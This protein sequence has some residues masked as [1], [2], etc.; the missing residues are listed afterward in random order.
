MFMINEKVKDLRRDFDSVVKCCREFEKYSFKDFCWARMMVGSRIFGLLISG[1]KT[2]VLVPFADMLN[3]KMPKQTVWNYI[4]HL[5]GFAIESLED[6]DAGEE[7]FDSYG[8]KCNTRFLL[9]YGFILEDNADNEIVS[10]S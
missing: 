8:R 1:V 6:I 5:N 9:N 7:V 10:L 3:H 2:E 4:E